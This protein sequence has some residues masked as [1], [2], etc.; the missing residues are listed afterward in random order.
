MG[1]VFVSDTGN[2]TIRK[3]TPS[4]TVTTLAGVGG[5]GAGSGFADGVGSAVRFRVPT[6]I[7]V[8]AAG[9]VYVSDYDNQL[10][11]TGASTVTPILAPA[12]GVVNISTRLPVQVGENVLIGGFIISGNAPKKVIIRAI[13][14]SLA[15]G[16][17][18]G[19]LADPMLTLMEGQT[20][21]GSNDDWR[22]T[23][24][25]QIID[26]KVAP[27]DNREAAIVVTLNPG[28]YTAILSGKSG[29]TGIGLVELYDLGTVSNGNSSSAQLAN[30]STRGRVETGDN[31]MI[32]GFIISGQT[33]K[34]IVRAIGPELTAAGVSGALQDTTLE[35]RDG[36]GSLMVGNDDWQSTQEQQIKDTGVPPTDPRESA[37]V[38]NLAPAAYTAIVRGKNN[39]TGIA[40]V[41]VYGLQ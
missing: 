41:E 13:G 33:R 7:A 39:A 24:E 1:N 29:G 35:L 27:T 11:R 20:L 2:N 25:Q 18:S 22:S 23:Q 16:G 19:A 5:A 36:N 12:A 32:G 21:R 28:F 38:A 3:I 30:I 9:K 17:V 8:D 40:L 26:T 10:V 37:V 6:G 15:A 4:G 14:P 34:V 31:V